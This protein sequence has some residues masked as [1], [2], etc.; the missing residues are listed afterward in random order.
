MER[1][2][3][4]AFP[5]RTIAKIERGEALMAFPKRSMAKATAKAKA[6]ATAIQFTALAFVG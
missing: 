3:L 6:K 5:K 4:I 2:A 1:D